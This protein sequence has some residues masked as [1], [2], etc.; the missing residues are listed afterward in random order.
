[1]KIS[2]NGKLIDIGLH[3]ATFTPSVSEDGDLSWS[4]NAG[5]KN[6][7]TVNIKGPKGE[8]GVL[9]LTFLL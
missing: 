1:M 9:A 7:E 2:S 6:P 3:G 4:N 5:L 8:P